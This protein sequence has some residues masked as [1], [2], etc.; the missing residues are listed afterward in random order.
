MEQ[1]TPQEK[2]KTVTTYQELIDLNI[3]FIN[4]NIDWTPFH[5]KPLPEIEEARDKLVNL[6]RLNFLTLGGQCAVDTPTVEKKLFLDGYLDPGLVRNFTKYLKQFEK[7][8]YFIELPDLEIKTNIRNWH[9]QPDNVYFTSL[10]R[11]RN[12]V[13]SE[14]TNNLILPFRDISYITE[15]VWKGYPKAIEILK[16]YAFVHIQHRSF[17]NVNNDLY[18]IMLGFLEPKSEFSFG[19]RKR[20]NGLKRLKSDLQKLNKI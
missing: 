8:E 2:Y 14:W 20:S 17:H 18:D 19:L 12:G 10:F 9:L 13:E 7:I 11:T 3:D 4:G 15:N 6:N 16:T 1:K 5:Q